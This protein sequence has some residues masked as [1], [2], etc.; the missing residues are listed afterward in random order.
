[1]ASDINRD[2]DRYIAGRAERK[3]WSFLKPKKDAPEESVPE[4]LRHDE[5]R[6][7]EDAEPGFWERLFKKEKPLVKE[8]LDDE[9]ME[10][11]EAMQDEIQHVE[12]Q[13]RE[14]PER[15]EELE[16]RRESL[17][18]RFF[19]FLRLSEDRHKLEEAAVHEI[20]E[21]EAQMEEEVKEV[22]RIV[23]KWL[24]RLSKKEKA[25]FKKS[26]DFERYRELLQKYGLAKKS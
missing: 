1:M 14:H 7:V 3:D 20:A 17:M 16:E 18:D 9:E 5:V 24:E 22:L 15:Y 25:N 23:H 10:R 21:Q 4:G 13:E 26:K 6:V 11:L 2:L 12:Q 8:D 19:A